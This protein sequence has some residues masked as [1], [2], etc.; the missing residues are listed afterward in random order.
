MRSDE[1][2]PPTNSGSARQPVRTET[3]VT[4]V[5]GVALVSVTLDNDTAAALRVRVENDIDGPVLP[6]R[7]DGVPASGWD[8]DRFTGVIPPDG[9]LSVGYACPVAEPSAA[10]VQTD[11]GPVS[12][13]TLGPAEEETGDPEPPDS[14]DAIVRSLGR[15]APPAD[16][17]PAGTHPMIS[18]PYAGRSTQSD[19]DATSVTAP[20]PASGWLDAVERQIEFAERLTD[21]SADEAAAAV[22]DCGGIDDAATLPTELDGHIEALRSIG[23]RADDLASRA[24]AADPDPVVSSLVAAAN[25][26]EPGDRDTTPGPEASPPHRPGAAADAPHGRTR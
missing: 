9:R 17:I 4:V 19:L 21:A 11:D 7:Q 6:P 15:A 10:T 13:E 20:Q 3:T 1:P 18:V 16:A 24:A 8:S 14:I 12:V 23:E 2:H 25:G 26:K 22:E 5:R